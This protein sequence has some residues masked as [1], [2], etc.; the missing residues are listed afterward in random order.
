[1]TPAPDAPDPR[2]DSEIDELLLGNRRWAELR[3]RQKPGVFD[4]L[5]RVHRPP[6]LLVGCCDARKP[7][8]LVTGAE[9]GR[10]FLHRNIANQVRPDDPAVGASFEFALGVLGVRHLVVCGHTGCGG[11]QASLAP[12]PGGDLSRWTAPV[13]SLALELAPELDAIED[14]AARADTLARRNVI[15]Q[16]ENALTFAPVRARLL[17]D[18]NPLRLHGWLFCLGNGLIERLTLPWERWRS[19]GRLP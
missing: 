3:V 2:L 11:I 1:M 7:M 4:E 6:F 19:E 14:P 10:L 13:R 18:E 5:A 15:R 17:D 12:D 16:L 8:D 9:P